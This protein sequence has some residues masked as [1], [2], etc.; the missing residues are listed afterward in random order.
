[1]HA[2]R[3]HAASHVTLCVNATHR[4]SQPMSL[5]PSF[6]AARI[7]RS[8]ARLPQSRAILSDIA[9]W[10]SRQAPVDDLQAAVH[11]WLA[12]DAA[13]MRALVQDVLEPALRTCRLL[14]PSTTPDAAEN[15]VM[16]T[17]E[18]WRG[19]AIHFLASDTPSPRP[20]R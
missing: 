2:V 8:S 15:L 9:D 6:T 4:A 13:H 5:P 16:A 12:V 20:T 7:G 3:S 18:A 11:E 17:Y 14:R 10:L 19:E 1:M